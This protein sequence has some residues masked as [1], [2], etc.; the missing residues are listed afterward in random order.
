MGYTLEESKFIIRAMQRFSIPDHSIEPKAIYIT[1]ENSPKTTK[2]I[3][4]DLLSRGFII[5]ENEKDAER[6]FLLQAGYNEDSMPIFDYKIWKKD[7][8]EALESSVEDAS[9]ETTSTGSFI[10]PRL[11]IFAVFAPLNIY[12]AAAEALFGDACFTDKCREQKEILERRK[13]T[14]SRRFSIQVKDGVG[15][16]LWVVYLIS[17]G[18]EPTFAELV[19]DVLKLSLKPL[20]DLKPE[21]EPQ[22]VVPDE[23]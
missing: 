19:Q 18:K 12:Y 6:V 1:F 8:G 22:Q 13:G 4:A 20:Y 23:Q 2:I 3:Q 9:E 11:L 14:K 16:L 7:L 17:H 21:P 5:V 15:Q 10:A